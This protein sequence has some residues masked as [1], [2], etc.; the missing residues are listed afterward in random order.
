M[1][2]GWAIDRWLAFLIT[3]IAVAWTSYLPRV[4]FNQPL[5]VQEFSLVVLG[6]CIALTFL[7][8]SRSGTPKATI[9]LLSVA[10]GI[11]AIGTALYA[12]SRYRV[13][14]EALY[15]HPLGIWHRCADLVSAGY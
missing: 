13:M 2:T 1:P 7:T 10:I 14:S 3:L 4:L 12:A 9:D 6:L 8:R 5:L 11:L 15:Y